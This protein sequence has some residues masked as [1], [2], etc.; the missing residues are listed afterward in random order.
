MKVIGIEIDKK[1]AIC[2]AIELNHNG[3][4]GNLNGKFKYIE[5]KDDHNNQELRHFQSQIFTF[6]KGIDPDKIAIVSRQTKGK[7]AASSIS[8]KLEALIQCYADTEIEFYSKQTL[9]AFFKKNEFSIN[10]DNNY[11]E[12]ASRLANYLLNK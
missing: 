12:N 10:F 6:F 8:F 5:I 11:Q 2:M 3:N 1:R 7:F 4:Y 9:N